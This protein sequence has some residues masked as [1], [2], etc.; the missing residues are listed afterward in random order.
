MDTINSHLI[1]RKYSSKADVVTRS[2]HGFADTSQEAYGAV[3]YLKLTHSD[4][5]S[6]TSIIIS[7]ARVI[8]LKGLT[9]L[10]AD[11][12][13]VYMLV[14]LLNYCSKLLDIH[15]MIAWNVL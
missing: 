3:V 14:K 12:T 2:L 6:T 4:G 5:T 11:L 8:P 13:A 15:S 1:Q 7:K 10:R 9:I